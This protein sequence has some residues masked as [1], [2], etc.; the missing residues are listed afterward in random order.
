M[1]DTEY[2]LK[3]QAITGDDKV[4]LSSDEVKAT[5]RTAQAPIAL[6]IADLT[7]RSATFYAVPDDKGMLYQVAQIP[8]SKYELY[9]N[10]NDFIQNY[11]Y[12]YYQTLTHTPP[13]MFF[14]ATW[15][16]VMEDLCQKG[17]YS[18]KRVRL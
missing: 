3:V 11:E 10:D 7:Y 15:T 1:Y 14:G 6:S 16:Q 18:W 12:G 8:V 4:A 17:D 13:Y 9:P 2:T 5:C